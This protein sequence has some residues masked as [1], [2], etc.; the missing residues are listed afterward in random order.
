M[1]T[2]AA[3]FWLAAAG[4]LAGSIPLAHAQEAALATAVQEFDA[5]LSLSASRVIGD[6][7]GDGRP[8]VAAILQGSGRR[9]LVVFHGGEEGF[10][11]HPLYA[12]LPEG[13][14]ELRLVPPGNRR[15]LGAPGVVELQAPGLELSFPG[16]SSALYA[17]RGGRYQSF[18]TENY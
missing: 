3:A 13:E 14:V 5:G 15:V 4:F 10:V 7:D 8:D 6:F 12:N 18:G 11:A 1:H 16:R 2:R 9:A 17:W